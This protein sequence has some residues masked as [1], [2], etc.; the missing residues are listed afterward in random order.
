MLGGLLRGRFE[1]SLMAGLIPPPL[2]LLDPDGGRLSTLV[3]PPLCAIVVLPSR[4]LTIV[5]SLS[6][7]CCCDEDG[8]EVSRLSS[9]FSNISFS[10]PVALD[11][12]EDMSRALGGRSMWCR[13]CDSSF[14]TRGRLRSERG[15]LRTGDR[16]LSLR[17]WRWWWL[18][19]GEGVDVGRVPLR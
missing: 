9:C 1:A 15:L 13:W 3:L 11:G 8:R 7:C 2:L 10:A 6:D 14:L 16:E 12:L 19:V 17:W 5:I 18:E 4:S